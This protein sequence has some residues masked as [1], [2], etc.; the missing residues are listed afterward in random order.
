MR[1]STLTWLQPGEVNSCTNLYLYMFLMNRNLIL[2]HPHR[3]GLKKYL[4]EYRSTWSC[5]CLEDVGAAGVGIWK[6]PL[7]S[8]AGA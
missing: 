3:N 4:R 6:Q 2:P 5:V 7:V 1:F 8:S